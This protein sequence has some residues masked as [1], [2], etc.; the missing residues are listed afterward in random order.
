MY[1]KSE[2]GEVGQKKKLVNVFEQ[3][4]MAEKEELAKKAAGNVA[5]KKG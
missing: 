2:Y 4:M 5:P 3:N 1:K